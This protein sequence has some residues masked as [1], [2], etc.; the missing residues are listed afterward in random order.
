MQVEFQELYLSPIEK[1]LRFNQW[2]QQN[3]IKLFLFDLDD[4]I[5]RTKEVFWEQL[6]KLAK[7]LHQNSPNTSF[8]EWKAIVNETN[9]RFYQTEGVNPKRRFSVIT[10]LANRF[11]LPENIQQQ[12]LNLLSQIYTTPIQ[13]L[14][15]AQDGL[16]FVRAHTPI[17]IVTHANR[18]WTWQ[19][20]QWLGLA[21]YLPWDHV[22][23]V[24]ENGQKTAESW[25][26]SIKYFGQQASTCAIVGDSPKSDINPTH[27]I[28]VKHRFFVHNG[29][30]WTTQQQEVPSD[31]HHIN[32][33]LEISHIGQNSLAS[34]PTTRP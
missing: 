8:D 16:N 20:Y 1:E 19:K 25:Q 2:C 21:E 22:Y 5:C 7:L 9:N 32:N 27:T 29:P 6:D 33:L 12:S 11:S 18:D 14:P 15:G 4:T 26:Q 28:G 31:T 30:I 10:D 17:G 3:N 24:N 34:L 23:I 13:W